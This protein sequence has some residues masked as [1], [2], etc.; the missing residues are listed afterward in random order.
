MKKNSACVIHYGCQM[1]EYEAQTVSKMLR[2]AG[3]E[4]IQDPDQAEVVILNTCTIRDQADR[5]ILNR[6]GSLIPQKR[7]DPGKRIGV[8][9]CMVESQREHL[10]QNLPQIDFLISPLELSKI[11]EVLRDVTARDYQDYSAYEYLGGSEKNPFR[12]YLPIQAGCNFNCTYCIVPAVKGR[13][14][15]FSPESL[16]SKISSLVKQG[17]LEITL[18]GQT[19]NSYRWEKTR[20]ADLLEILA[21][22]FPQTRFRFLTSHPI[23]FADE[24]LEAVR[25][26]G[27][28]LPFFHLPAQSGSTRVLEQM[29]RGYTRKRYLELAGKIREMVPGATLSTD[30]I[31]GF[32]SE[33]ELEFQE[34]LSL[35]REV[36]FETSFLFYYSERRNT[37]AAA[38]AD[39][40]PLEIRKERLAR[41][42][43]VQRGIQ[44]EIYRSLIGSRLQVLVESKARRGDGSMKG[45]TDGNLPVVFP[46]DQNT[47]GSLLPVR[48]TGSTGHTLLG[49]VE[50]LGE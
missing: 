22:R 1:N 19:I 38:M 31:C 9:G 12:S 40:I 32:P 14:V 2:G 10:Q 11:S 34:S 4:M 28:L 5:K 36:K 50:E 3:Y 41:M 8:M 17:V 21:K 39:S 42:I 20:F 43:E 18:L 7:R 45:Y 24:I 6:L 13:E 47:V 15:N 27:N 23:L 30:M 35:L 37:A 33:T 49:V 46:A 48:I 16:I 26:H 44:A 29:K 25:D